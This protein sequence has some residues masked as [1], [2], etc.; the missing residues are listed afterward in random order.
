[1][2][3]I[4]SLASNLVQDGPPDTVSY[5]ILGY[6]IIGVVGLGYVLTLLLRQRNL[7]RELD[8]LEKLQDD[9]ESG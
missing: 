9:D 6:V 7:D 8:T 1:M 5:L 3:P 2:T 4:L